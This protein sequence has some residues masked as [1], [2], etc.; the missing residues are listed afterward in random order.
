MPAAWSKYGSSLGQYELWEFNNEQASCKM[1][2]D[3]LA[4]QV[5]KDGNHAQ[6]PEE[7]DR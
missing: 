2:Q 7:T 4:Y 5:T 1:L 6:F 3:E